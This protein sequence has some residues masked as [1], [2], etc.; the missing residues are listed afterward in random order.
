V[1]A[2]LPAPLGLLGF[3]PQQLLLFTGRGLLGRRACQENLLLHDETLI[4]P[5]RRDIQKDVI[6]VRAIVLASSAQ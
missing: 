5:S 4:L 6:L 1:F 3:R 2:K